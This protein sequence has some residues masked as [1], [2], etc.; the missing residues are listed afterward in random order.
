MKKIVIA[1]MMLAVS[2]CLAE[3]TE[4]D[5]PGDTTI[6]EISE[7][8]DVPVKKLIQYLKLEREIDINAT[9]DEL[10]FTN[11]SL[12]RAL[13]EY[14]NNAVPFY[15]GIVLVGMSIVFLSLIIIGFFIGF[16]QHTRIKLT[17]KKTVKTSSGKVTAS[18]EHISSNG[19][20][21]AI[22][23]LYLHE[24]EVE[25]KNRLHLTWKRQAISL[26]RATNVVENRFFENRK[27]G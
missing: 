15:R 12:N 26:W 11:A 6:L 7:L 3:R 8:T 4:F 17:K 23:A 27:R 10:D 21:A 16:L 19:I 5:L 20:V 9:M 14:D 22:T 2:I 1:F 18:V 24:A 25:E 13:T